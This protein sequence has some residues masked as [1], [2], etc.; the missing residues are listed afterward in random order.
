MKILFVCSGNTC[1]SCMAEAIFNN[2]P[3]PDDIKAF[4]CGI[5]IINGSNT[6]ENSAIVVEKMINC[7]ISKRKAVQ[8]TADILND[9]TLVLTM[10]GKIENYLK[11]SFS[12]YSSKIYSLNEYIGYPNEICDPFGC[13]I[14]VY[15]KIFNQLKE[16]IMVL[17][18]KL[19]EKKGI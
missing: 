12:K 11:A 19:E 18:A 4:S 13:D 14:S 10:T 9:S 8:L 2:M 17:I 16:I 7:D 1:R 6:S 5:C 15:E 3:H